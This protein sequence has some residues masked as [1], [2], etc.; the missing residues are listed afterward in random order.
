MSGLPPEAIGQL[1]VAT[2]SLSLYMPRINVA[3]M[4]FSP[5][6]QYAQLSASVYYLRSGHTV[7]SWTFTSAEYGLQW[8]N[9]LWDILGLPAESRYDLANRMVATVTSA[10]PVVELPTDISVE[11]VLPFT[12][13]IA[14]HTRRVAYGVCFWFAGPPP[15]GDED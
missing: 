2:R 3:H 13:K 4:I 8:A 1:V 15:S 7:I 12:T 10:E 6:Y 9:P 5:A 11:T 14:A